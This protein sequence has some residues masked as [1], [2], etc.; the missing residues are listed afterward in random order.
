MNAIEQMTCFDKP[1]YHPVEK[2]IFEKEDQQ[3]LKVT[4][5]TPHLMMRSVQMC[6]KDDYTRLFTDA[7][8][9]AVNYAEGTPKTI[10]WIEERLEIWTRRWEKE[11][12]PFSAFT[13]FDRVTN[14]FMGH[15]ALEQG[16]VP[17]EVELEGIAL[18]SFYNQEYGMEA[19]AALIHSFVPAL[20]ADGYKVKGEP[21]S[22]IVA[23]AHVNNTPAL[24]ILKKLGMTE[25]DEVLKFG[26]LRKIFCLTVSN[27]T[28][29]TV[30]NT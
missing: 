22:K 17:G 4:L 12:D 8:A 7:T 6:D 23:T 21:L 19:A 14:E 9:I 26:A 29:S 13:V 2:F 5:L 27:N 25:V 3:G 15:I 16:D 30:S 10:E 1:V 18:P 20:I 28:V 24:E 11:Q